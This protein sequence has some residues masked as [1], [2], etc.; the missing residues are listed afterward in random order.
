[1]LK[2]EERL[3]AANGFLCVAIGRGARAQGAAG[4]KERVRP[5][6]TLTQPRA[7][8]LGGKYLIY[9]RSPI[10]PSYQG[11]VKRRVGLKNAQKK[12]FFFAIFFDEFFLDPFS[13]M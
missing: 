13:V 1:M 6:A 12:T 11:C 4:M 7:L 8:S 9:M 2:T 3:R 5:P 10:Q